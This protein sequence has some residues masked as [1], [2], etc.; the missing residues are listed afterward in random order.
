M[1]DKKV[2]NGWCMFDWANSVYSLVITTAIFP[3]YYNSVTSSESTDIVLFFGFEM[4]NTVLYSYALSFSFLAVAAMLPLLSGIADYSGKKLSFMKGF[5]Y[6]GSASCIALFFFE[7]SNIE[8]GIMC[9]VLASIGFS[10][11]LVFYNSYLPE[12]ASEDKLDRT[13]AKGYSFG[14]AGSIILL[15]VNLLMIQ[16]PEWFGMTS[17]TLPARISF[18]MVGIWWFGFSQL[19]FRVLPKSAAKKE[20]SYNYLIHG[21]QEIRKVWNSLEKLPNLKKYLLAFF[22]FN[23]GVQTV[24]YLATLFGDKELQLESSELIMTILIIQFVAIGGSYGFARLSERIGNKGS[25]TTMLLIWVVVCVFAYFVSNATEFFALAFVVGSVMGGIQSLARATYSKL[26]PQNT[27][28]STSYFSFYNITY[29]LSIVVGT[30]SYGLIEYLTGSMRNSSLAL[31]VFFIA[32]IIVL[33]KVSLKSHAKS[34]SL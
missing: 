3:L 9:S 34:T 15:V 27:I 8:Y 13:S 16:K 1:N 32:G 24:M 11:G 4:V 19:S 26:I 17:G 5:T 7:G 30:F 25:L 31:G 18:L 29:N 6:L 23:T 28:D 21:Y 2:I 10:G 33:R 20:D 22:L 12:I 14:Y